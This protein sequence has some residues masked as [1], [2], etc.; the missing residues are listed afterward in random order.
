MPPEEPQ[1]TDMDG[2]ELKGLIGPFNE[3]DQLKLICTT[4]GGIQPKTVH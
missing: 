1:I 4:N 2:N 3:A